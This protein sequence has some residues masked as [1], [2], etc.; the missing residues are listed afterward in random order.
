[1]GKVVQLFTHPLELKAALKLKFL[2][3]PLYPA[4]DTQGSAEL[5]RCYQLLQRTS[6]SFAAVIMELHPELRNAVMLFYLIL[7]ALDTVEDDMTISPKVKVPLLR[8]FDQKLK[9]DTWSFDGNAKTEKDRDVLVEFSTIL[10]EFHKLKP[11]YQQVI[12]DITHK[13]GNGMADYILDEKFNLSGLE[14]IQ[15]YDRYCH[16]VAGLVGDGLTHLIMLA[17]FSSPG[18]YYDSPDLYES[19][20]LFLQKTNIIR[21]YA[22]DLADGRSFWPKEIWSHYADDLASFSKPENATAG[23][24]CINHLVLN[25]LGHVQHVLTY[26]ASLREQSSFQFCAIPQVMAIATLAL[27]FGNERV[28]QTSVKIR[29]GTTCYLILKSRTFQGCVEIFEHYLRDIRKRLT[30]ADPNYLKLNIE[31][32]KLD[33][34]IEEMYQDKLPVG[35]KPQ[36]T[37]IYKKVRERSAYDLEVLPREQEEEFKFNVLLSILFT[38]FGALYWYAK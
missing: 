31:I 27:V 24:Y 23:V 18:L 22:E 29:K 34:F 30:V 10:A 13:M 19:M 35:A 33:K 16:Y 7:R 28:L 9:L 37:E 6:R 8:E 21:D 36:E 5:K 2:R 15:D 11:E 4:D 12:A 17:K 14:T 38:V 3:E 32:A 26:L 20:G 1:M 25:A